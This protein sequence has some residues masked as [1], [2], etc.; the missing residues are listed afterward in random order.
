[1]L[2]IWGFLGL[3][4][5]LIWP[6]VKLPC[7]Q[8]SLSQ[9][10]MWKVAEEVIPH[11]PVAST[12]MCTMYTEILRCIQIHRMKKKQKEREEVFVGVYHGV[13]FLSPGCAKEVADLSMHLR[14]IENLWLQEDGPLVWQC[15]SL[16]WWCLA[17]CLHPLTPRLVPWLQTSEW[18]HNR[19]PIFLTHLV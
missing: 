6:F 9:K 18:S 8:E 7:H 4:G 3:A 16:I 10:I 5:S 13:C 15:C 17:S 11:W 14:D 12:H 19:T 2:A 1:M